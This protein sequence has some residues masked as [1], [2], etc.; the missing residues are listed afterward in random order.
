MTFVVIGFRVETYRSWGCALGKA[1][2]FRNVAD[3]VYNRDFVRVSDQ[4]NKR[5]LTNIILERGK[6]GSDLPIYFGVLF[7][8]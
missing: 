7:I 4:K 6:S 5:S 3:R 2:R 1:T 8:I